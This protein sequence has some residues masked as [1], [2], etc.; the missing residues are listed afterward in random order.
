MAAVRFACRTTDR[1]IIKTAGNVQIRRIRSGLEVVHLRGADL[2]DPIKVD[3]L[4]TG[5]PL[6][7]TVWPA[8]Y[9][10]VGRAFFLNPGDT[11]PVLLVH[12]IDPAAIATVT[13]DALPA[14]IVDLVGAD[15]LAAI[16]DPRRANLYNHVAKMTHTRLGR[17]LAW[18]YVRAVDRVEADRIF[19]T[20]DRGIL[21]AVA[22][23]LQ[24]GEWFTAPGILHAPPDGF[25][26]VAS[27]K[28]VD[29]YGSLQL[30]CFQRDE[31]DVVLEADIDDANGLEHLFQVVRGA[32]GVATSPYD[33]REIL[34]GRQA[35]PVGYRFSVHT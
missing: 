6:S 16:D 31:T 5:E 8:G 27:V 18:S 35:L 24:G 9:R 12:P 15:R 22:E 28:T 14:A 21:L 26:R 30:V 11:L 20:V 25:E 4:P 32:L 19:C 2:T 13:F 10:A 34:V 7:L 17:E 3:S 1:A 33:I 23:A 29:P